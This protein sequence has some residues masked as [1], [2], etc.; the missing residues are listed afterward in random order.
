MSDEPSGPQTP[1]HDDKAN[2]E[3]GPTETIG[4]GGYPEEGPADLLAFGREGFT[5]EARRRGWILV[6]SHFSPYFASTGAPAC[7]SA[8]P[9]GWTRVFA[10]APGAVRVQA[11]FTPSRVARSGVRC[12]RT[13]T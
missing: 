8:A 5:V 2:E 6:R 7:L 13:T 11:R 10:L 9:G 3:F 12:V 4:G 1:V